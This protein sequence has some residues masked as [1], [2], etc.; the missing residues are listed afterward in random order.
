MGKQPQ[1]V[2]FFG[3]TS[4]AKANTGTLSSGPLAASKEITASGVEHTEKRPRSG[5]HADEVLPL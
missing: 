1:I 4:S 5:E 3:G 2:S